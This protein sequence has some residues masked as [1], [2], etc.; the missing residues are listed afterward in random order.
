MTTKMTQDRMK[1]LSMYEGTLEIE[2]TEDEDMV[3][4]V[5]KIPMDRMTAA[6]VCDRIKAVGN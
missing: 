3:Y 2:D 1:E 5:V 4:L 6:H